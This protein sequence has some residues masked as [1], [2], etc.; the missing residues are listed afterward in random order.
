[1]TGRYRI[2]YPPD[3]GTPWAECACGATGDAI[4]AVRWGSRSPDY[5]PGALH[6]PCRC[7]RCITC[8]NL[9]DLDGRCETLWCPLEGALILIPDYPQP[10]KRAD[11]DHG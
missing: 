3:G 2:V 1:M 8:G 6:E 11:H 5:I 9:L 10:E 4:E 7:P